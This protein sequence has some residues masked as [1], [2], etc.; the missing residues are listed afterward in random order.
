MVQWRINRE[1]NVR[2]KIHGEYRTL[3]AMLCCESSSR[4]QNYIAFRK[5]FSTVI[6]QRFGK[7]FLRGGILSSSSAMYRTPC[8]RNY[9]CLL[10][11]AWK[12]IARRSL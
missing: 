9:F 7:I 4:T 11:H 6:A 8:E 3:L 5:C 1:K 2:Q 12:R 10:S